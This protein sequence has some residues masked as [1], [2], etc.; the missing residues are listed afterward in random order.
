RP[1]ALAAIVP[2]WGDRARKPLMDA[3]E[4]AEEPARIVA[5]AELRRLRAI[6]DAT[7]NVIE[8]LLTMK[9]SAS[10]ELRVA[11]AAALADVGQA[12]RA[13]AVALLTKGVE[14]RRG[15]VAMLRGDGATDESAVVVESMARAR[16]ALDRVEGQRAVKARL[17]KAD[18]LLRA[19]LTAL[20]QMA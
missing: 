6:D 1:A 11:A 15:L 8:R 18:A 2:L 4:F 12:H 7:V 14:G 3:L 10:E 20:L 19:R 13:R 9:G 16:L 5:V 17:S